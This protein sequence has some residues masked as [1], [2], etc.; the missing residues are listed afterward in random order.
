MSPC[1]VSCTRRSG[2]SDVA[3]ARIRSI[4]IAEALRQPGVSAVLLGADFPQTFGTLTPA[5][6]YK[7]RG[8]SQLITPE[9]PLLA[10]DQVRFV[11][12]EIA[13]VVADSRPARARRG[14]ADRG[15]L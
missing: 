2:R 9:R 1:P 11:G 8:G 10:R 3:A 7:G 5:I 15:G 14:G 6:N 4:D 12:E 13:L